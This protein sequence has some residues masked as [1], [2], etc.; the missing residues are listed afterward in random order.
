VEYVVAV[1]V[2]GTGNH[3]LSEFSRPFTLKDQ[4]IYDGYYE[5]FG[6]CLL[7]ANESNPNRDALSV[8]LVGIAGSYLGV[9]IYNFN[10]IR[11]NYFS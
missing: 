10:S 5:G 3:Q 11:N 4:G 9:I 2:V 1:L 8:H 7:R 6:C